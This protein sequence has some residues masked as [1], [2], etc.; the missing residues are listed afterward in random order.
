MN[1]RIAC[2]LTIGLMLPLTGQAEVPP[3]SSNGPVSPPVRLVSETAKSPLVNGVTRL[4]GLRGIPP[5][6]SQFEDPSGDGRLWLGEDGRFCLM[7]EHTLPELIDSRNTEQATL[8]TL[9]WYPGPAAQQVLTAEG[10]WKR[11]EDKSLPDLVLTGTV[12]WYAVFSPARPHASLLVNPCEAVAHYRQDAVAIWGPGKLSEVL[13][14]SP[15]PTREPGSGA[16]V[17]YLTVQTPIGSRRL[18]YM[19]FG[20]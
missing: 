16:E 9:P 11:G 5:E 18:P 12:S 15:D 10:Q 13:R 4:H 20:L 7:V 2:L 17:E 19:G 6:P 14:L 3:P 1:V 8:G